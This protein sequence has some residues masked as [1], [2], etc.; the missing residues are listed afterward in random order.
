MVMDLTLY[1]YGPTRSLKVRWLLAELGLPFEAVEV[2]LRRGEHKAPAFLALNPFGR[3]PALKTPHGVLAESG[4]ILTWLADQH[5]HAGW[6]PAPGTWARALHDQWLFFCA[7]DLE[8]PLARVTRH[9]VL[10]PEERRIP[11]EVEQAKEDFKALAA[12]VEDHLQGR[13]FLVGERAT[14]ADL[15]MAF[16]LHWASQLRLLDEFPR[17]QTYLEVMKARPSLPDLLKS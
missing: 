17:L 7:S 15:S 2:D 6:I 4:A 13:E 10:Y 1:E 12:P 8:Q 9:S 3:L 16:A 5:P 14:V 11:A